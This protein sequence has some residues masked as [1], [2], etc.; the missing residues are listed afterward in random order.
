[1]PWC[2]A[3]LFRVLHAETKFLPKLK[4]C[5]HEEM[6]DNCYKSRVALHLQVTAKE[7]MTFFYFFAD[8]H[9]FELHHTIS[10]SRCPE[11]W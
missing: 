1:M 3:S 2:A 8:Q 11:K 9:H 4:K 5:C 7:V 10:G 6:V